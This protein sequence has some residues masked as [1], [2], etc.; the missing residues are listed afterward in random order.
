MA[1]LPRMR[2]AEGVLKELK[3]QDPETR[4]TLHFIRGL[5]RSGE[6]PVVQ[7]GCQKL[8]NVDL[9]FDY[10]AN[11]GTTQPIRYTKRSGEGIRS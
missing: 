6:I 7:A 9:V 10:L 5:I 3:A 1:T 4:I 8:V 11:H 2:S